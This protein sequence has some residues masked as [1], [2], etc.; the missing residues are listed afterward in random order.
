MSPSYPRPLLPHTSSLHN[1][2]ARNKSMNKE[3]C[4]FHFGAIDSKTNKQQNKRKQVQELC[5]PERV[6][7]CDL[8]VTYWIIL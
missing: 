1:L 4:S 5:G 3:A 2:R 7:M 8:K 6:T